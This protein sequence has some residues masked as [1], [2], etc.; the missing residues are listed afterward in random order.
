[1]K[2]LNKKNPLN[3]NIDVALVFHSCTKLNKA[4]AIVLLQFFHLAFATG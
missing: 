3:S 4:N 2:K 1:M